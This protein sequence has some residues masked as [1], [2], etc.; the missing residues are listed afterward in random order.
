ME[1]LVELVGTFY[2]VLR[3][4]ATTIRLFFKVRATCGKISAQLMPAASGA[5]K[6]GPVFCRDILKIPGIQ[7]CL[8]A[9]R[10]NQRKCVNLTRLTKFSLSKWDVGVFV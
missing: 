4:C 2:G 10:G 8:M 6:T 1:K 7:D 5:V 9:A 3:I